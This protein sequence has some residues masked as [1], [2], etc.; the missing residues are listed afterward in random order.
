[1]QSSSTSLTSHFASAGQFYRQYSFRCS[2]APLPVLLLPLSRKIEDALSLARSVG[3]AEH[4][5][6][7]E[8]ILLEFLRVL[9]IAWEFSTSSVR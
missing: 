2:S 4:L 7:F 8:G 5:G 6:V 1:M 3:S 9:M